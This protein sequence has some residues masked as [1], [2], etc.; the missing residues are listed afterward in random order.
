MMGDK[1]I[2]V[3]DSGLGGLTAVRELMQLLP[4]EKIIYFGDTARLPYGTRSAEAVLHFAQQDM[5]FM[6][7]HELKAI[8]VACG[9]ISSVALPTLQQ[10]CPVRISGVVEPTAKAAVN[11]TKNGRI[12][13]LGTGATVRS[14]SYEKAIHAISSDLEVISVACPMFVQLVEN[15]YFTKDSKVAKLIAADY[16]ASVKEFGADTVI[17]GCTHFPLLSDVISDCLDGKATLVDSGREGANDIAAYL[18]E[19]GMLS[20][21]NGGAMFYV[22]DEVANFEPLAEIFLHR[23]LE[24][25]VEKVNIEEF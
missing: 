23:P 6:L 22:S 5:R 25:R 2:G 15:G 10:T 11:T 24:G 16:L 19:N 21:E 1:A 18:S 9:T 20:S 12:A 3:F 7:S 13:V 4:D 8:L 17:L 14:R